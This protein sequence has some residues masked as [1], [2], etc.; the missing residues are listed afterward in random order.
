[1]RDSIARVVAYHDGTKH[2]YDRFAKSQGYLDWATQ[3]KPFRSYLGARSVALYPAPGADSLPEVPGAAG[4]PLP[5]AVPAIGFF[6]RHALGLSAWKSFRGSRWSLRVNPSSGNLHPTEAYIVADDHVWHYAPDR[7]ALEERCV[8]S[9][10]AWDELPGFNP[11]SAFLV[12]LTSIHWRE[13]WKYGERAFRYCHHDVGHAI[14]ALR[15][16]AAL[17]GWHLRIGPG[18]SQTAMAAIAGVGRDQDFIEAEREDP[19][20]VLIVS[21]NGALTPDGPRSLPP[22]ASFSSAVAGGE[23]TGRA[24]QLSEGHVQWTFIDEVAEATSLDEPRPATAGVGPRGDATEVGRDVERFTQSRS[25]YTPALILQRR[26]AV[27]FDGR[28]PLDRSRVLRMLS[29][30]LPDGTMPWDVQWWPPCIHLVLFVHRVTGL[31]AGAYVLSRRQSAEPLLR[32]GLAREFD[33]E[34]VETEIPLWRL[35]TADCRAV[36]RRVS[37]NQDIAADGFFSVAMLAEFDASL[38]EEGAAFYR[39]LYWETGLIGQ[40]LYL[41]AEAA[42]ARATGIGCFFDDGVHDVLGIQDH[43][44][45]SLYHFTVGMPVEDVRLTTEPGYP[46]E[47]GRRVDG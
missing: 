24:S 25:E 18:W 4:P 30:V 9:R 16:A 37:C 2:H 22:T 35:A 36:A 43:A 34:R 12:V 45:Q 17:C 44:L 5:L 6:L 23:W 11:A 28:S 47:A 38:R 15:F 13:S 41:E 33:W 46:W 10:A 19:A 21:T 31:D 40:V 3:P 14:G 29:R 8:F 1:V 26:S 42:G 20:C 39:S 27:A 32:D 7:H